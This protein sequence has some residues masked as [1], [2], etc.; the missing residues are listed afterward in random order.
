MDSKNRKILFQLRQ[1][2]ISP[3][4]MAQMCRLAR[5]KIKAA[6]QRQPLCFAAGL[7]LYDSMTSADSGRASLL[8]KLWILAG[9][10]CL[11]RLLCCSRAAALWLTE[12][13]EELVAGAVRLAGLWEKNVEDFKGSALF[14][15][16][17]ARLMELCSLAAVG[18]EQGRCLKQAADFLK[19][20]E[21][22]LPEAISWRQRLEDKM[23]GLNL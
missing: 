4:N 13:R 18:E 5:Q 10:N 23:A 16:E 14:C 17:A 6:E 22:E 21:Q 2:L 3:E 15:Q 8:G 7:S 11:Y 1:T 9:D 20:A 19:M 12:G